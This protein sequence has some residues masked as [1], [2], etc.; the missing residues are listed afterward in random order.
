[1][2]LDWIQQ[3]APHV[4]LGHGVLAVSAVDPQRLQTV[5]PSL[6]IA[7]VDEAGRGPLIGSVVTAAVILDPNQPITGLN[8]SKKLSEKKREQL[9][10]EI[11]H[12][13]L[14]WCIAE[15]T[16]DEID[17]LNILQATMLAMRRAVQGLRLKPVMV[18]VDGN[19]IP[20]LDIPA[21]AIVKGDALVQSISAASILAKVH[22]DRWCRQVHEQYP[23]Y[24]FAGHKGYGTAAHMAALQAHGASIYHRRSFAPVAKVLASAA[25]RTPA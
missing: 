13:A 18:L 15:A 6:W 10:I 21:E 8:D 12:K 1:M 4:P 7:G 24:G 9:F 25:E 14:A 19:R 2:Q 11:Q 3:I 20:T 16:H 23:Q 17:R 22:R 5:V